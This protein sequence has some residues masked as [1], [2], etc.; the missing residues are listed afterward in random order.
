M[1]RVIKSLYRFTKS[2]ILL[3]Q[4]ETDYFDI[5]AGVRQGCVLSPILFSI[6]VNKLAKEI[7]ESGIGI[8]VKNRKISVLLYADDI[9][10]ITR[11]STRPKRRP[12]NSN[13]IRQQ[14]EMQIQRK[15]NTS[16]NIWKKNK[17]KA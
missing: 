17:K 4:D 1:W 16:C 14:M 6:F 10:I 12:Q 11:Q 13:T 15:K 2:K 8:K 3:G 9:V 5:E 7:N